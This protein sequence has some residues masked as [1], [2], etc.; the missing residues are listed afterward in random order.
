MMSGQF[1]VL[2]YFIFC[3]SVFFLQICISILQSFYICKS[4]TLYLCTLA[5]LFEFF[6]CYSTSF[7]KPEAT[8]QNPGTSVYN[9]QGKR[10]LYGYMEA[11]IELETGKHQ[12]SDC[13]I[14]QYWK[15]TVKGKIT[16][17]NPHN[18]DRNQVGVI[19]SHLN[20]KLMEKGWL[21]HYVL[22]CGDRDQIK[23]APS[24]FKFRIEICR[25]LMEKGWPP[26]LW[27]KMW[28]QEPKQVVTTPFHQEDK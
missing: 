26:P 20:R 2:L 23:V 16:V 24:Y 15:I 4:S 8:K 11:R 5:S 22:E 21:P 28:R 17:P 10:P 1:L 6:L 3:Q 18:G 27:V 13:F 14:V 12:K 19:L 9:R 7:C 25:K